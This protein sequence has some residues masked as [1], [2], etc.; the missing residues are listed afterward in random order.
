[1]NPDPEVAADAFRIGASGYMLKRAEGVEPLRAVHDALRRLTYTT[2]QIAH[3][4]E[5][6]FWKRPRELSD[7]QREVLQMPAEGRTTK[8]IA[9]ILQISLRTVRFHKCRIMKKLGI[10]TNSELVE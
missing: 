2:P 8:E 1:M 7:R 3:I 4:M 6:M 10:S 5:Q 9:N